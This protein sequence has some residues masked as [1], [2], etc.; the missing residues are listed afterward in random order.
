MSASRA[1]PVLVAAGAAIFVAAL[2]GSLTD[3]GP[4]YQAL[5]KPDWQPPDPVFG[6]V[7]TTVFAL[8]ALAAVITWR[9]TPRGPAREW[10]I[11]LLAMNGFLNVL[12]SL[13]FFRLN[14]PDWALVEVALFWL[15]IVVLIFYC[16]RRVPS[17]GLLLAPYLVWVTIA[18]ALNFEI[19]RL[20]GPFAP[21]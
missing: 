17:A 4:W 16:A 3:L 5:R 6:L 8:T 20:N 15:S 13:L 14:R 10:L 2:G 18:A 1:R 9:R 12:W 21:G 11:G 7:W 19:V